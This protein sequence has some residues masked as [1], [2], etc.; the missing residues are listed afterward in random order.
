MQMQKPIDGAL[1]QD[2]VR[3]AHGDLER[4]IS[5][6]KEEPALLHAVAN[7]GGDDWESALGAAAHVGNKE[8]VHFL[9]GQGARMDIFTAA[10]LGKLDIVK[11]ILEIQ[12]NAI[13]AKGPHGIPLL[14]HA[15]IGGVEA[16]GVAQYL[17]NIMEGAT[18]Q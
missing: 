6:Y 13:H 18:T 7:W 3:A 12:P 14:R 4:V 9:L 1:V 8:I 5:L 15:I 11:G 10:M 17:T 2:F 16:S